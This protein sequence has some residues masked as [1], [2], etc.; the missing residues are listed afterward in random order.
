MSEDRT[1]EFLR[2]KGV[3]RVRLMC[4]YD[5][6]IY[7]EDVLGFRLKGAY[8][9][10]DGEYSIEGTLEDFEEY[11]RHYYLWDVESDSDLGPSFDTNLVIRDGRLIGWWDNTSPDYRLFPSRVPKISD[12]SD[13]CY[14]HYDAWDGEI[15]VYSVEYSH[16]RFSVEVYHV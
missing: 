8:V 14:M 13:I 15:P 11:R 6:A 1:I 2:S 5:K 9:I 10:R 12:E 4:T 7:D 3:T 16:E